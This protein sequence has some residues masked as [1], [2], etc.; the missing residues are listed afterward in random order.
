MSSLPGTD[1]WW[2]ILISVDFLYQN[3]NVIFYSHIKEPSGLVC[4]KSLCGVFV[5]F[6][7]EQ[8]LC[9][10]WLL[11]EENLG[12]TSRC[13]MLH[14]GV[15]TGSAEPALLCCLLSLSTEGLVVTASTTSALHHALSLA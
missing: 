13:E 3:L 4:L 5:L 8:S 1:C 10:G 7:L 15:N 11:T 14:C 9:D 2:E 6:Y 12:S